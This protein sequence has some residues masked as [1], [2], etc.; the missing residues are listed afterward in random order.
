M[1]R[2][3]RQIAVKL[4]SNYAYTPRSAILSKLD[5]NQCNRQNRVLT[6]LYRVTYKILK[7]ETNSPEELSND[8]FSL[9]T[10]QYLDSYGC[11]CSER[12]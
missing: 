6:G 3:L 12:V 10:G 11:C 7:F 1:A 4:M 5:K 8:I 2:V 9:A